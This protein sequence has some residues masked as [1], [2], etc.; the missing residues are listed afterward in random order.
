VAT[1]LAENPCEPIFAALL[2]LYPRKAEIQIAA[3][4]VSIDHIG[5]AGPPEIIAW[6]ITILPVHLQL[7]KM[8]LYTAIITAGFRISG[9]VDADIIMLGG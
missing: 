6:R 9:L 1:N 2:A 7:F 4:K 8:I 5:Y 3:L